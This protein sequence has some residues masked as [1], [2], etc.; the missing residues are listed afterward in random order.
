MTRGPMS[1]AKLI[2][3]AVAIALALALILLNTHE[4]T[5]RLMIAKVTMPLAVFGLVTLGLGFVAGVLAGL[6]R[7]RGSGEDDTA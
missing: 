2:G 6:W 5:L 1:R 3:S 7:G 4:V